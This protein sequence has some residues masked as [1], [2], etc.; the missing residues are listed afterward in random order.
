MGAYNI[1]QHK[2]LSARNSRPK[3]S[4]WLDIATIFEFVDE[5]E[6]F[7]H[8]LKG[9]ALLTNKCLFHKGLR[10]FQCMEDEKSEAQEI[11]SKKT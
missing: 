6:E 7:A 1:N 5:P 10:V 3:P 2:N 9:G 8:L 11:N 4:N